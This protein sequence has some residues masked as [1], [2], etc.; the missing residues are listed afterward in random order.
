MGR[1]LAYF[2]HRETKL[3]LIVTM[4]HVDTATSLLFPQAQSQP[5]HAFRRLPDNVAG[6]NSLGFYHL[7][8]GNTMAR[9]PPPQRWF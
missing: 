4:C 5:S 6:N 8:R 9:I 1:I 7:E 3:C 2:R